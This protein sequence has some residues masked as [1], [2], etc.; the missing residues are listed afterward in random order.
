M[1]HSLAGWIWEP[2]KSTQMNIRNEGSKESDIL[3][4]TQGRR[5][6]QRPFCSPYS[7]HMSCSPRSPSC[8]L[9]LA[10]ISMVTF[11]ASSQH[12]WP[13]RLNRNCLKA[14]ET[15]LKGEQKL[16]TPWLFTWNNYPL[17][18]QVKLWTGRHFKPMYI[19]DAFP[20]HLLYFSI[21]S[22]S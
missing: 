20:T 8:V 4:V 5:K 14:L 16:A 11:T 10:L 22:M 18:F 13:M 9:C 3:E 2:Q 12:A 15:Y 21:V 6:S 17:H 1:P 19:P 7:T